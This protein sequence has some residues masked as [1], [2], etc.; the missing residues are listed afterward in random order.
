MTNISTVNSDVFVIDKIFTS[1]T[2]HTMKKTMLFIGSFVFA[3][4]AW[5]QNDSNA[6]ANN[7]ADQELLA[8]QESIA[9]AYVQADVDALEKLYTDDFVFVGNDGKKWSK[10]ELLNIVEDGTLNHDNI[11]FEDVEV[12]TFD[13]TAV[14][15]GVWKA[16]G[17][18]KDEN[19]ENPFDDS[20]T[21]TFVYVKQQDE[22]KMASAQ[23]SLVQ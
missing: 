19:G 7:T 15:T 9:D 1:Q 14:V 11:Q 6:T 18:F 23:F 4:A 16:K 22:W 5:A 2:I 17:A 10:Q 21:F 3:T 12:R 8:L 20:N 13:N